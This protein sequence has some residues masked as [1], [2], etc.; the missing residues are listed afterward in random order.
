[1]PSSWS[2]DMTRREWLALISATPLLNAAPDAPASPVA[3]AKCATYD[4]DVTAKISTLFDQ[5]GGIGGLVRNKTVTVKVNMTGA[6]SQKLQG[7]ALGRTHYTHPKVVGAVAY[8]LGKAGAKRINFVESA[9]AT[10]GP[11]EDVMLDS[12]WNV[13]SLLA[14]APGVE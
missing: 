9:W 11:L 13:R 3:I 1:P 4:E 7:L 2:N 6:P 10:G 8:L 12:G 5:I 14:A